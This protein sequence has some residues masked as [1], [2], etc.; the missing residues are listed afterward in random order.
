MSRH[1]KFDKVGQEILFF[2]IPKSK[3]KINLI[4][5]HC[6]A[7]KTSQ[8]FGAK[9]CD[10][11]HMR[12][13]GKNS[14]CGYHYIIRQSGVI[15]QGR[16]I[17][18]IGAHAKGLN[19]NSI[20]IA[21]EGGLYEDRTAKKNGM[22]TNQSQTMASLIT[23]IQLNQGGDIAIKGHNELPNV[24]KACPCEDMSMVRRNARFEYEKA[25]SMFEALELF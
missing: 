1:K 7:T 4:V 23:Q 20:G 25:L 16:D 24:N 17:D 2:D 13:W 19:T 10:K 18:Y 12:R 14:G 3:R 21:Y 15:E 22:N 8:D 5:V 6:T 9:E 11:E